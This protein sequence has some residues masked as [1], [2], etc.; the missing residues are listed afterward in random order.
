MLL[1]VCFTKRWWY[2]LFNIVLMA[3]TSSEKKVCLFCL[4]VKKSYRNW[5]VN[6][7]WV[8][9]D[10][11]WQEVTTWWPLWPTEIPLGFLSPW[12]CMWTALNPKCL[13]SHFFFFCFYILNWNN[14]VNKQ[15]RAKK[16]SFQMTSVLFW[17][18]FRWLSLVKS[19]S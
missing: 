6:E 15:A 8:C 11:P 19:K 2:L 1:F 5:M 14:L 3:D 4:N 10:P 12:E 17:L 18:R 9:E 7:I 13:F 16:N